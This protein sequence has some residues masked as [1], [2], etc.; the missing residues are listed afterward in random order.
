VTIGEAHRHAG[1]VQ[2]FRRVPTYQLMRDLSCSCGISGA[3]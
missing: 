1:V 3:D 2:G